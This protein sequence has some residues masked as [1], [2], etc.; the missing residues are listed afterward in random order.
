M[1][2]FLDDDF[3]HQFFLLNT[4]RFCFFLLGYVEAVFTMSTRGQSKLDH[5]GYEYLKYYTANGVTSWRCVNRQ[6]CRAKAKT[7][8]IGLKH[9]AKTKGIHTCTHFM[10]QEISKQKFGFSNVFI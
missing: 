6:H 7:K 2:F 5:Q 10:K 9:M 8:L 3:Q 1:F 4:N